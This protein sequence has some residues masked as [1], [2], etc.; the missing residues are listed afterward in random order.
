MI[1]LNAHKNSTI[2]FNVDVKN[3]GNE[4]L[5]GFLRL[6]HEDIEYGFPVTML[7]ETAK[8]V[9]PALT[10]IIPGLN[11]DSELEA[12]LDFISDSEY[13][14]AWTDTAILNMPSIME[15]KAEVIGEEDEG[16][17]EVEISEEKSMATEEKIIVPKKCKR[18]MASKFKVMLDD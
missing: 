12:R 4:T 16:K 11:K 6:V 9:V 13:V 2:Q 18:T 5:K 15:A 3:L 8:I 7:G 14:E 17:L 10:D 1:K